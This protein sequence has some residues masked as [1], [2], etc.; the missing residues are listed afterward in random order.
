MALTTTFSSA[1]TQNDQQSTPLGGA[2]GKTS[3]VNEDVQVTL[4]EGTAAG[5]A[6]LTHQQTITL[7]AGNSYEVALDI[8][9]GSLVNDFGD[10]FNVKELNLRA[11]LKMESL[12]S[13]DGSGGSGFNIGNATSDKIGFWD[14]TPIIQPK[15]TLQGAIT[16]NSGG[17]GSTV[18]AISGSGADSALNNNFKAVSNLLLAMRTAL[19]DS[20]I[21]KGGA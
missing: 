7:N 18:G 4:N 15:A 9:A 2:T 20:G 3:D 16:D 14:V 12:S 19:V 5:E 8:F 1:T 17:S 6:D 13:I 10:T 11:L 21:M